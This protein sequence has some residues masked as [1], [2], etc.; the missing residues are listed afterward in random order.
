[1]N[2][3][4]LSET[5]VRVFQE[6]IRQM[7]NS[8]IM[9][10][11]QDNEVEVP[12][13]ILGFP[14]EVSNFFL[15]ELSSEALQEIVREYGDAGKPIVF[16]FTCEDEIPSLE[17]LMKK[18]DTLLS[19]EPESK[20]LEGMPYFDEVYVHEPTGSLRVRFHYIKGRIFLMSK[21]LK[22]REERVA[23]YGTIIFRPNRVIFEV[24]ARHKD[25][26]SKAAIRVAAVLG[27][28][29]A[30]YPPDFRRKEMIERFLNWIRSLNNARIGFSVREAVSSLSMSA[31]RGA[32]LRTHEDFRKY[33][34]YGMLK[35]GHATAYGER[36]VKGQ[37]RNVNFRIFFRDCRIY[38]TRF[39]YE[40][41]IEYVVD[42][43]EE[44]GEGRQIETPQRML[45]EFSK[46][47]TGKI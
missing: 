22:I 38:F 19:F 46:Q 31:R 20:T 41:D 27:I 37:L 3:S 47:D 15:K 28:E 5:H 43:L 2:D 30:P 36:I 32:D 40:D 39:S 7:P 13:D 34:E 17:E 6:I 16:L 25:V 26:A 14:Y 44:I 35:G 4:D 42:A 29:K 10:L 21:T 24:R 11:A 9:R 45:K 1:M 18:S 8:L 12:F 33:L 23:H